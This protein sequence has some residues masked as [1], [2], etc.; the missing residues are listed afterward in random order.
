VLRQSWRDLL[1]VHW[2]VPVTRVRRFVPASLDVDE[3]DGATWLGI[4]PFRIEG[5]SWRFMP[6][7]PYFSAF[8]ELNLRVYVTAEGKAGVWFISLDAD[9]A[10]AVLGARTAFALPYW[11][12][13]IAVRRSAD[14]VTFRSVRRGDRGI[15]FN[16]RYGPRGDT[17]TSARG[18][19]EYFL[20]ERYCLYSRYADGGIRRLEIHHPPWRLRGADAEIGMNTLASGQGF[21]IDSTE[22]PLVHFCAR[23]DV[24]AWWPERV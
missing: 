17:R 6:D 19:L 12:A 2:P 22:P 21:R 14:A 24:L 13:R 9:N 1:F 18:T 23:Q 20:T 8:P 15:A 3:F 16:I 5:L 11:R 7:L 10:A 4:V